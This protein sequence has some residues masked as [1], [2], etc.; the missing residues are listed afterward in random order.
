MTP[1]D[2]AYSLLSRGHTVQ[3]IKTATGV[4]LRVR[5]VRRSFSP[6]TDLS[7]PAVPARPGV[8]YGPP[9]YTLKMKVDAIIARVAEDHCVPFSE[10]AGHSRKRMY[11]WARQEA[12]YLILSKYGLSL[13]HIGRFFGGRDHTTIRS[14]ILSHCRR[15]GIDYKSISRPF[16]GERSNS[17]ERGG[18]DPHYR[19]RTAMEYRV[20]VSVYG[21]RS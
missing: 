18:F 20:A 21:G 5:T 2:Y 11:A 17:I 4:D 7:R 15:I 12:T 19:P 1:T 6:A 3:S 13:P 8:M 9:V 16:S 10:L 14:G